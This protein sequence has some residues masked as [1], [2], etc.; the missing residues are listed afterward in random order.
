MERTL[1]YLLEA[2]EKMTGILKVQ[3]ALQA[4]HSRNC[5][6]EK[7]PID[8]TTLFKTKQGKRGKASIVNYKIVHRRLFLEFVWH[9]SLRFCHRSSTGA[10]NISQEKDINSL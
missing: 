5:V 4:Q 6:P 7:I 8:M 2:I 10:V 9:S 3:G 1:Q